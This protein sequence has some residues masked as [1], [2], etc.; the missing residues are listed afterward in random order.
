MYNNN[1]NYF[2]GT[3]LQRELEQLI[4]RD[5]IK[6]RYEYL[7]Q[8]FIAKQHKNGS[9]A[10]SSLPQEQRREQV[11]QFEQF[12]QQHLQRRFEVGM[13]MTRAIRQKKL[14]PLQRERQ[15]RVQEYNR[16]TRLTLNPSTVKVSNTSRK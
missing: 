2:E 8:H 14:R 12:V 13:K 6:L 7:L 5:H 3:V 15:R 16:L 9:S 4:A 11:R 10:A 1:S